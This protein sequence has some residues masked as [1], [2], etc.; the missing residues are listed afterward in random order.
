[1][2]HL[3]NS[4]FQ[5]FSQKDTEAESKFLG[6]SDAESD[7]LVKSQVRFNSTLLLN[8]RIQIIDEYASSI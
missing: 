7:Q 8:T 3:F 5:E 4:S 6:V 1:M 2:L